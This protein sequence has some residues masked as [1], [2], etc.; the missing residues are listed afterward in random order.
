VQ[1]RSSIQ[2]SSSEGYGQTFDKSTQ[3]QVCLFGPGPM[4]TYCARRSGIIGSGSTHWHVHN[5]GLL[6]PP[7][8]W[9]R[10][11]S[12]SHRSEHRYFHPQISASKYR[13]LYEQSSSAQTPGLD[14]TKQRPRLTCKSVSSKPTTSRS[15]SRNK[16]RMAR[17]LSRPALSMPK[18]TVHIPAFKILARACARAGMGV[19]GA[20]F[21]SGPT[22]AA[23]AIRASAMRI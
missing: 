7:A 4:S 14:A 19:G 21:L 12:Q 11:L 13:S 6:P 23:M 8:S 1:Q 17:W 10:Q 16:S 18:W 5:P 2:N 20:D 22:S 3:P 9:N 15:I